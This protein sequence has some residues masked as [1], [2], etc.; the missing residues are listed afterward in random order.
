MRKPNVVSFTIL[1]ESKGRDGKL[2]SPVADMRLTC[3]H[4]VR[5]RVGWATLPLR[6]IAYR[7]PRW[8]RCGN[9]QVSR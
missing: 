7:V 3:G 2:R 6:E 1:C 5:R 4:T 9:C 8:T